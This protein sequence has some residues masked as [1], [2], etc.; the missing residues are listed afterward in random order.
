MKP[1]VSVVMAA[2]N[3]EPFIEYAIQSVLNQTLSDFELII[4]DDASR[5]QTV[6]KIRT[7]EDP[8]IRFIGF[9]QNQGQFVA[10]NHGIS[11]AQGQYIAI[12]NSDDAFLPEKLEAQVA[13][14]EKHSAVGAVFSDVQVI[15]E[16]GQDFT[17]TEHF[18]YHIFHHQP[19]RSRFEWLNHFFYKGNCLCH[20]SVLV[21]KA[22]HDK[23]GLY[24]TRFCKLADMQF[25][26]RLCLAYDMHI[27][28][29]TLTQFRVL[30]HEANASG[31]RPENEVI[32]AWEHYRLLE[33][34]LA[35]QDLE[36]Y[37]QVFP[38][39]PMPPS[40]ALI[41]GFIAL[42][43]LKMKK[44]YAHQR[45][46]IQTLFKTF[47]DPKIAHQ[48]EEAT[49]FTDEDLRKAIVESDIF[50]IRELKTQQSLL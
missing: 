45:F 9:E 46:A 32:G 40:A 47:E 24:D 17:N 27:L 33:Q 12:L 15:N 21:R 23:L 39:A 6:A 14:L 35:I 25:W 7:F 8:R 44:R 19:N 28:P 11:L 18:Y 13:F 5:D 3:H 26:V 30:P 1:V 2:Y 16:T 49:G 43:A 48:L 37:H 34:Y 42:E 50:N 36:T 10:T 31:N 29:E 4:V 38:E 22:C 20:P 41:S